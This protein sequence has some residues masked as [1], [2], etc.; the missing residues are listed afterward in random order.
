[1]CLP[2]C[3]KWITPLIINITSASNLLRFPGTARLP[4]LK[5]SF[6]SVDARAAPM[7]KSP[8]IK[9][10]RRGGRFSFVDFLR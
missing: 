2:D 6:V 3:P 5:A 1:M 10:C 9:Y 8:S 7:K 4:Y